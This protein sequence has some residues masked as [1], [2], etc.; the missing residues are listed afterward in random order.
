MKNLKEYLFEQ[1][2]WEYEADEIL[3]MFNETATEEDM[4]IE[5]IFCS[6][7]ELGKHYVDTIIG[8]LDYN[9][10]AVLDY[11][12]LGKHLAETQEE[13]EMLHSG[14]IVEFTL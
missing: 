5:T 8:T 3:G 4:Q 13:Y 7:Y 1:G 12:K 14:R 10:E 6:A 11:E 2:V 9:I